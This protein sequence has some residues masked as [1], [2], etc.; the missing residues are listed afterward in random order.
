MVKSEN[1]IVGE[2]ENIV[3]VKE[4]DLYCFYQKENFEKIR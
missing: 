1:I 3:L 2:N 4:N